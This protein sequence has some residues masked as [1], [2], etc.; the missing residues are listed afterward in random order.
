MI[1][2][3]ILD[4]MYCIDHFISCFKIYLKVIDSSY[5]LM[6][7]WF[8]Y[9]CWCTYCRQS[10]FDW[11]IWLWSVFSESALMADLTFLFNFF[12]LYILSCCGIISCYS[13]PLLFV[14]SKGAVMFVIWLALEIIEAFSDLIRFYS[15]DFFTILLNIKKFTVW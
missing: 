15:V 10:A 13:Y 9:C 2:Y 8:W 14:P 5:V 12:V 7:S 3:F 6:I 11:K 4:H 1:W